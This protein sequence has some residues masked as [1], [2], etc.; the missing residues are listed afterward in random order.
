MVLRVLVVGRLGMS[1]FV[2][3]SGIKV[4]PG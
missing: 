4:I 2:Q 3:T 1:R